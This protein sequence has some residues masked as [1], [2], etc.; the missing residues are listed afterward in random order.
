MRMPRGFLTED[1]M[2]KTVMQYVKRGRV[3]MLITHPAKCSKR[4]VLLQAEKP[5]L[6]LKLTDLLQ[7]SYA[8]DLG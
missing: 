1:V 2:K 8:P 4:L 3:D 7:I 6:W 5:R